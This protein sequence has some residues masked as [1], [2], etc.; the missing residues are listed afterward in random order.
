MNATSSTISLQRWRL[1]GKELRQL[2]PMLAVA[3]LV[4]LLGAITL[5][6]AESWGFLPRTFPREFIYQLPSLIFALGA[7][8]LAVSQEKEQRSVNWLASLPIATREILQIKWLASA[9]G[10]LIVW[11][12][13]VA[14]AALLQA[15]F[16]SIRGVEAWLLTLL[17]HIYILSI[18]LAIAWR[19]NAPMAVLLS[20]LAVAFLPAL[21]AQIL[22]SVVIEGGW[23][24]LDRLRSERVTWLLH[25][26]SYIA[27]TLLA[28]T[29]MFR[30]GAQALS[31]QPTGADK[32]WD[33]APYRVNRLPSRPRRAMT[34][35]S[36][37][38]WQATRQQ[39]GLL[40]GIGLLLTL[41]LI[42]YSLAGS[43]MWAGTLVAL[44]VSWLG[45]GVF[46]GENSR[47][48]ARFFADRGVA[49]FQVWWTRQAAPVGLLAAFWL[50]ALLGNYNTNARD[51]ILSL[52]LADTLWMYLS[53]IFVLYSVSQWISQQLHSPVLAASLA[54]I[55]STSCL[56]GLVAT[57][58]WL[59]IS[60]FWLST[61]I[62]GC[63]LMTIWS[64]RHWM[65]QRL[66]RWSSLAQ[67]GILGGCVSLVI[68]GNFDILRSTPRLPISLEQEFSRLPIS[69]LPAAQQWYSEHSN[70]RETS[71]LPPSQ[72]SSAFSLRGELLNSLDRIEQDLAAGSHPLR[73]DPYW[74]DGGTLELLAEMT[75][76]WQDHDGTLATIYQRSM[77]AYFD[78][79]RR[80]RQSEWLVDQTA[81]DV[82]EI[83]LL[84]QLLQP[85]RAAVL[86]T[87]LYNQLVAYLGNVEAR[88][89]A[90]RRA[91]V[92]AW[93]TFL[94]RSNNSWWYE[95][96][97]DFGGIWLPTQFQLPQWEWAQQQESVAQLVENL[98]SLSAGPD[99][100]HQA[101]LVALAHLLG[102]PI[103]CYG[104]G[105]LGQ[106]FRIDDVLRATPSQAKRFRDQSNPGQQ[107][108]AG[109]ER[110]AQQL[111]PRPLNTTIDQHQLQPN[112][113]LGDQP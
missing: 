51:Q 62:A 9:I 36:G 29:L 109:W 49:P 94:P 73:S 78:L 7:V 103:E 80:V 12:G 22:Y 99:I 108:S 76:Q 42:Y 41:A 64:T 67:V 52:F 34:A 112:T 6:G 28:L 91:I 58:V 105:P 107:W 48:Q 32:A 20:L 31:A 4:F 68:A 56:F 100:E 72:T 96:Q 97:H 23:R 14:A 16:P 59:Q 24:E 86:D 21:L 70:R 89:M 11:T 19:L 30:W 85:E 37:L 81:A 33:W 55:V 35:S 111:V 113:E 50:L 2:R 90:R 18:G 110:Q 61:V 98:W 1:L 43:P 69:E 26:A 65:E 79:V 17:S 25:V 15:W 106:Y 27:S 46:V 84:R 38:L 57:L 39:S 10:L 93:Q 87:E 40:M 44:A 92:T 54:P 13:C 95:P 77:Q 82:G 88:R 60:S 53:Y 83:W 104:Q 3:P 45:A 102:Q 47:R 5:T 63:F 66:S 71:V 101:T 75:Q 8:G 74:L